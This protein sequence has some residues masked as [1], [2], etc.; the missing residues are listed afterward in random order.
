[1]LS[2]KNTTEQGPCQPEIAVSPRDL[3]V[4]T[5]KVLILMKCLHTP[6]LELGTGKDVVKDALSCLWVACSPKRETRV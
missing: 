6:G 1:M 5:R 2:N 3:G 4:V